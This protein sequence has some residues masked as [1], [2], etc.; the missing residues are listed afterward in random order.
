MSSLIRK[1][2][3]GLIL[4]L[5][6]SPWLVSAQQKQS[7]QPKA[8]A[9]RDDV[10]R[11]PAPQ[12]HADPS[13]TLMP[14]QGRTRVVDFTTDE[15]TWMALDVAPNGEWLTFD[16]LGHIY[17]LPIAGGVAVPLTDNS[18]N[19][20]NFQPSISP[21]GRRIAF[22]SD[23]Q[24]QN[25][26]WVME[27]DGTRP[28]PVFL[29]RETRFMYPSWAPDGR[30]L[31]AVRVY[32]TPG[33]GWH[34]QTSEIWRLPLDGR[35][36]SRLLGTR[37]MHYDAPSFSPDG[38]YLYFHVSYSTGDGL[39]LLTAGHRIQRLE[40]A[41]GHVENVRTSDPTELTPE[42][43]DALR[44]TDRPDQRSHRAGYALDNAID[45]P[46]ALDPLLSPDGRSV[47]FALEQ[48]GKSMRYRG[49]EYEP[50]TALAVRDLATGA[51]RLVLDPSAKDL[52]MVNAQYGYGS[53]P[54]F[55]W[56]P[57]S[58]SIVAWEGGKLRRVTIATGQVSTIPFTVHVQRVLS[59]AAR[60]RQTIDDS[61]FAVKF[62]QWPAGSP[63]GR[64]LAFVAVGKVWV[65]DLTRLAKPRP[66]TTDMR[67]ALQLT[68]SWSPD[69]KQIAFAT[70]DDAERGHVWIVSANGGAPRRIT[71]DA[72]EYLYPT[73]SPNGDAVIVSRG[74][75]PRGDERWNGWNA[76][77]WTVVRV[78]ITGGESATVA[79]I[80]R[81]LR[82]YF[83]PGGRLY[84]EHYDAAARPGQALAYPFPSP[85]AM[86]LMLS[87]RSSP[88]AGGAT[89]DHVLF[90]LRLFP[91]EPVLS[92]NGGWV[93]FQ[94]GR[95]LFVS[96]V[97]AHSPGSPPPTID[98]D[99]N[100]T[101]PTRR[102]AGE[103]GGVHHS[104]R[105]TTTLQFASGNRYVTY[106]VPTGRTRVFTIDLRIPRPTPNGSIAFTNA[107]IITIDSGTVI[108]RGTVVVRGS[109]I[110][111]VGASRVCD[112]TGVSRVIDL[113]GKVIIPGLFDLHAHHTSEFS[114]VI[115]PHRSSSALDLAYGVT[116]I[117]DPGP[118]FQTAFPL[119]ELIEA[120]V[121]VG[122]RT[123]STAEILIH[124]G[125]AW[126]DQQIIRTQADAQR[127]VDRRVSWG[128]VS[129]KNYRQ[130]A[131]YQQ[132]YILQAARRHPVTVTGEGGPLY[133]D[134][135]VIMDGQTGWEHVLAN[136]PIYQ[137]AA[138]FFGQAGAVYSPTSIVAGHVFGSM[139]YFR[140]R[141][142]LDADAKYRRFM[143]S[144]ELRRRLVE[145]EELP[146]SQFSFPLIAEGLADIIRAGGR[147]VLGEHGEQY[148]IGT[149]WEIWA[150]AEALTP[151]EALEVA[152][153]DG[154]YAIGLERETGSITRGKLADLVVLNADPL[155]N[156]RNTADVLY[157]MK[158]GHLYDAA[159]LDEIWPQR[160]VYGP[161]P[162][163]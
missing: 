86:R 120:G 20:L 36:P 112:A 32:P 74:P 1:E 150:Y 65:M 79:E 136:I 77:G 163:K 140:P 46:A 12:S 121:I 102:P 99:P 7:S 15:G 22:I 134:V 128:A 133:F 54:R 145:R 57:D 18:G 159:T 3:P 101:V 107:K 5:L 123:F 104:W 39:G 29:D 28:T 98:P 8:S 126:G 91:S 122:P 66:L 38:R 4:L 16:L 44:R 119:A 109:R 139:T 155:A 25:N 27:A 68:P 73:W 149:H 127:E 40:L 117:L 78:P 81:A 116:T 88:D 147:G 83:G 70:W 124:P 69:G 14:P 49:H 2:L 31:V 137:D 141:Q 53:F 142:H 58:K 110:A 100:T 129:I 152:T 95:F 51:E 41:T 111:C 153:I 82:T 108:D 56:M 6:L 11:N 90:P 156:I 35:G 135:G 96:P 89:R 47:A 43:V 113:S 24:G 154:A 105:D 93:A 76:G 143:P 9:I 13:V 138:K 60:S 115:T 45:P 37:L 34:R 72:T 157:T 75:G 19:A 125:I 151:M 148:G 103:M 26:V 162:W 85:E 50:R 55:A 48:N 30:S 106:D 130:S 61:S 132:Q 33:R 97:P 80:N 59:E 131:R 158:A 67:P 114:G 144:S 62:I 64:R 161:I 118:N 160:R 94:S 21:D 92:P 63:D 71:R 87:V 84:Y 146:K 52:T 17:R 10:G 42:F 23:R